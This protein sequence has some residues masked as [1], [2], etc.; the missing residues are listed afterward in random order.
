MTCT[1]RRLDVRRLVYGS[2]LA[3]TML[4]AVFGSAVAQAPFDGPV[5]FGIILPPV[6]ED[7]SEVDPT[8][9]GIPA[10]AAMQGATMAID[11]FSQNAGLL[12]IEL[13]IPIVEAAD[14]EEA[15]A[16]AQ[17]LVTE[18]GV[19]GFM[20]GF[21]EARA[22]ALAEVAAEHGV[23]FLNIGTSLGALRHEACRPTSF[24]VVPSDAM[25]LDATIGFF[26]RSEFRRWSFVT[27]DTERGRALEERARWS[28]NNRHFGARVA[29]A[30][31][32]RPEDPDWDTVLEDLES[33]DSDIVLMLVE[34]AQQ[35]AL[36]EAAEQSEVDAQF[37]GFPYPP[38]QTR[39]FYD[40]ARDR[41]PNRGSGYW[42]NAWEATLDSY[43][44]R[45]LNARYRQRFEEPM[46][47]SAWA[48]F[49]SVKLLYEGA[50]F[51][52]STEPDSVIEQLGS[53]NAAFDVWKG[54]GV[55]FRPWDNQLRQSMYLVQIT[56]DVEDAFDMVFL[57][58]ELPALYLPRTDPVERLDQ[59]GDLEN[60]TRCTF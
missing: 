8:G 19:Y 53:T 49:V 37:T 27:P 2:F 50:M 20:G 9:Y 6:P 26:V 12:G 34:P 31:S 5:R 3:M 1:H 35:L 40:A 4:L 14:A 22:Q 18:E 60:R 23:P 55:S 58:G 47:A 16:E 42:T 21:G 15:R 43:G 51:G 46:T 24:H 54:I 10:G 29:G 28:M 17:R 13:D 11:E 59:L 45:E 33:H 56:P 25:Y 38:S 48:A 57:V 7:A 41:A 52:Q 32:V 30:L 44:A 39:E 36:L